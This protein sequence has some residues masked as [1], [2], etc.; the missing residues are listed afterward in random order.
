[1]GRSYT[2]GSAGSVWEYVLVIKRPVVDALLEQFGTED[3]HLQR[4][5]LEV[6]ATS[7]DETTGEWGITDRRYVGL[8]DVMGFSGVVERAGD[9]HARTNSC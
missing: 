6:I 7:T 1:M 4:E 9:D 2:R 3:K 5:V 8:F